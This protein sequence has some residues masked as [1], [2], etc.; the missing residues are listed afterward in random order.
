MLCSRSMRGGSVPASCWIL[1]AGFDLLDLRKIPLLNNCSLSR[2][3]NSYIQ[4]L[5]ALWSGRQ[6]DAGWRKPAGSG[7]AFLIQHLAL[8]DQHLPKPMLQDIRPILGSGNGSFSFLDE[9]IGILPFVPTALQCMNIRVAFIH[10]LLRHTGASPFLRS[11]TVE[12]KRFVLRIFCHPFL[13]L[14]RLFSDG[15]FDFQVAGIPILI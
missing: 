14:M 6:T 9:V 1:L 5:V 8:K 12:D 13:H 7:A 15:V 2:A 3:A 11:G 10:E 4:T